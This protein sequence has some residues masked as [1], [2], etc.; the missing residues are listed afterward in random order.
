MFSVC[1]DVLQAVCLHARLCVVVVGT[2]TASGQSGSHAVPC[3]QGQLTTDSTLMTKYVL[4]AVHPD[5][6][7]CDALS[8]SIL[9]SL[10]QLCNRS[11][12]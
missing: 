6:G 3:Y 10:R 5:F 12:Y 8:L 7:L 1:M 4:I 2:H 9:N 11:F